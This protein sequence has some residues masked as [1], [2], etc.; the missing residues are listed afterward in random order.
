MNGALR[1]LK[2]KELD[3]V[4]GRVDVWF[5]K[6]RTDYNAFCLRLGNDRRSLQKFLVENIK[7]P[8]IPFL[9]ANLTADDALM[10]FMECVCF[11]EAEKKTFHC[12]ASSVFTIYMFSTHVFLM[13]G[14]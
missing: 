13:L 3:D 4:V 5:K 9:V 6:V 11:Q 12:R 10:D 8:E 1:K 2:T 14:L 7:K